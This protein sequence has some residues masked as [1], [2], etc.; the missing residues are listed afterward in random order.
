MDVAP[1][2]REQPARQARPHIC[3]EYEDRSNGIRQC[4]PLGHLTSRPHAT[5]QFAGEAT[6][7]HISG[8]VRAAFFV[9]IELDE[10]A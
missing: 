5:D 1:L 4:C 3:Q 9:T 7:S 8:S 6:A 10:V 2:Y